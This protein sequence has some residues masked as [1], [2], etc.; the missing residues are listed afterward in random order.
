M[1]VQ[2]SATSISWIPSE[3]VGGTL[4]V[5]FELGLTHFDEPPPDFVS[6]VQH[7]WNLC[8]ADKFRFSNVVSGWADVEDGRIVG[9]GFAEESGLVMG[10]TT[11]RVGKVGA[12][13]RA[14]SLPA[15]QQEP[16]QGDGRVTF[17]Q[18]VG[19]ATGAPLPRPVPHPPF[20]RWQ[21]PIV[22]TTLAL[23]LN[24]DGTSEVELVGAS[25]FPRHWVYGTDGKLAFKSGLTD[26]HNWVSHSFGVRTPWG[27]KD[28]EALVVAVESALE[29]QLS[30][31]I[32]RGGE[33]PEIRQ[34]PEG[35]HLT[36]QGEKGTELYLV[37]DG[38]ID[39][40]VDG[41][42]V[43]QV[44]PG[45]VLGE[46][47]LLEGGTRTST[48]V[49]STAVRVAVASAEQVDVE[50]LRTLSGSHRREEELAESS[51]PEP[52]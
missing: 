31:D 34:L 9:S 43:A 51:D 16:Q 39:V 32:M 18:T 4:R 2:A 6:G 45:A 42:I 13:F 25:A 17:L 7:V 46:R 11:L 12:T 27:E 10:S 1:R 40:D 41:K 29:R 23:H 20:V 37:L 47:A 49:A 26:Q 5:G 38:V 14:I 8:R 24:A 50:H 22:W 35:S 48:L 28:R 44:G 21:A 3:S 15:I 36:S 33:A 30:T 52:G 19:G